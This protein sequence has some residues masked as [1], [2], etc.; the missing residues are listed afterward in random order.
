V[1]DHGEAIAVGTPAEIQ[2]NTDVIEAY[3]GA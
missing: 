2:K 3:L 1:I